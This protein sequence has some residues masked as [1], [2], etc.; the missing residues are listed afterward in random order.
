MPLPPTAA[1]R[2]EASAYDASVSEDFADKVRPHLEAALEPGEELK[3][4]AAATFQKTFSGSL[5]A[6]GVTDRRLL[7]QPLDRRAEPKGELAPVSRET[8][9]SF[10]LDGAGGGWLTAPAAVLDASALTLKL[11]TTSG[12]RFKLMMMRGGSFPFGGES[13]KDGVLALAEWLRSS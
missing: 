3:G 9:E 2:S 4:V 11:R 8:L 7:L 12:E 13:Q 6:I 5:Y 1:V 10:E